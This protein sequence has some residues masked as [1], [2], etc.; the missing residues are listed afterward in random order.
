VCKP[1]TIVVPKRMQISARR[2]LWRVIMPYRYK[3]PRFLPRWRRLDDRRRRHRRVVVLSSLFLALL[4]LC[5]LSFSFLAVPLCRDARFIVS[6]K[7]P[8]KGQNV[9][10]L[11]SPLSADPLPSGGSSIRD[12]FLCLLILSL[13]LSLSLS[14]FLLLT[15]NSTRGGSLPSA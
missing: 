15:A 7:G 14:C 6:T 3:G 11:L 13:S 1:D 2:P 10:G 5:F 9:H 4:S 12:L 8:H